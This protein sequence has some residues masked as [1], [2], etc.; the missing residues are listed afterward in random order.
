MIDQ[1]VEI[2]GGDQPLDTSAVV[3]PQ[4]DKVREITRKAGVEMAVRQGKGGSLAIDAYDLMSSTEIELEGGEALAVSDA[5]A[6]LESPED[7]LRCQ[8]PFRFSESMAGV[9]RRGYDGR[10]CLFDVGTGTTHWL[11]TEDYV[12]DDFEDLVAKAAQVRADIEISIEMNDLVGLPPEE[13]LAQV[14]EKLPA[15]D[16]AA[17]EADALIARLTTATA[18]TKDEVKEMLGMPARRRF[19]PIQVGELSQAV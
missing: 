19:E 9:L 14:R 11:C 4:S 1:E 18:R 10:A 6:L 7:K 13:L 2:I 5:L 15:A 12:A 8:T 16:L 17:A 3:L